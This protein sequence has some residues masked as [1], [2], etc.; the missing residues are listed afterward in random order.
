MNEQGNGL[1]RHPED[2][3]EILH[4]ESGVDSLIQE[5]HEAVWGPPWAFILRHMTPEHLTK[6]IGEDALQNARAHSRWWG[7]SWFR[8]AVFV[9]GLGGFLTLVNILKDQPA[10]LADIL[11]VFIGLV[12]GFFGGWGY[13]ARNKKPGPPE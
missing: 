1:E 7:E 12:A 5:Q 9:I 4:P 10:L 11:K 8:M 3:A 13:G 6:L 2:Q